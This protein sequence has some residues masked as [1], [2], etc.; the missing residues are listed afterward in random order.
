MPAS[1]AAAPAAYLIRASLHQMRLSAPPLRTA[2]GHGLERRRASWVELFFD[3]VFAGAVNQLASTLQD[4][5]DLITLARFG[6][7]FVPVWW[8]WVQFTFYADRH[9]SDD[10][11][12][13]CVVLFAIILCVGLAASAARAVAGDPAGYIAAF[14]GL[15]G[16]QLLLYARARMHLPATRRLYGW[17]LMCFG[18]GGALWLCSLAVGG[19]PRYAVWTAALAADAAGG[20]GMLAPSRYVPLN[21]GHLTERFQ[22]FV[23][24][25]LGESVARLISAATLRPWSVPLAVVL[26]AASVTLAAMWWAWIRSADPRSLDRPPAIAGFTVVNLPIV[27]GIAAASAGLHIAVLAADGATTIGIGPRAAL[28]GGVSV[29][30]LATAMMP[31]A[32]MTRLARAARLATSAAAM[33]LV[34][35]GAIVL[36]VY[37]V[38][39]LTMALAIGL[40][41]ESL[42]VLKA[43]ASLGAAGFSAS[44]LEAGGD[45]ADREE[46][47][48]L[49]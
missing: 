4:H 49:V 26:T 33:G 25:V 35:M 38:P 45:A 44:V 39:A 19:P 15:R 7:F 46:E 3:L 12:H 10:A 32:R 17:Y 11:A 2:D 20:L 21:P 28:Y 23:L 13:R 42:R 5:P 30:L 31:S 40:A 8:L 47:Q 29:C 24:I 36:P 37:L 22:L 6:F 48:A 41:A 43:R 14:G 1:K 16:L 34:F 9:E 18:T 27:A